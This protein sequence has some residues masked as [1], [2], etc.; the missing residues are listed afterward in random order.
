VS[1]GENGIAL[2]AAL[3]ERARTLFAHHLESAVIGAD[4]LTLDDIAR[5]CWKGFEEGAISEADAESISLAV[6]ARRLA[7][8]Q[9]HRPRPP[10]PALAERRKPRSRQA[11]PRRRPKQFGAGEC[12]PLDRNAKARIMTLARALSR[13][14]EPGRHYGVI[15]A[16]ALAV[17]KALLWQFHNAGSGACFPSYEAIAEAVGCARSTVAEAL[18][19]LEA[20]GLLTWVNRLVRVWERCRDL[21]GHGGSRVRVMRTS[22]GYTLRDPAAASKSDL[23]T[24]TTNQVFFPGRVSPAPALKGACRYEQGRER[25][26]S[27]ASSA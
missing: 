1:I 27:Y 24:G 12:V 22:N 25:A 11:P 19:A 17:L 18:K 14:T 3:K 15:S 23:P 13:R 9:S 2:P 5:A 8:R 21:F 7:L 26:L 20:A 16:K 6:E 10:T 4:S